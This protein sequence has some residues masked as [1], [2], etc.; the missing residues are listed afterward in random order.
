MRICIL[1]I[2]VLSAFLS[3]VVSEEEVTQIYKQPL[4]LND[5]KLREM[6]QIDVS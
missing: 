1:F 5:A 4:D 3:I 2:I 6:W